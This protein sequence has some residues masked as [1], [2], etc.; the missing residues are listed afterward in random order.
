[1]K[2]VITG[3]TGNLGGAISR[4]YE[5]TGITVVPFIR[6]HNYLDLSYIRE[7]LTS[8]DIIIHAG[9]N[10]NV[11]ECEKDPKGCYIS[12][13]LFTERLAL[14]A[15][16]LGIK[17]VYISSTGVYGS[18]LNT[19]YNEFSETKP[20]TFHHQSKLLGEKAVLRCC[21]NPIIVRTGWLFGGENISKNFVLSILKQAENSKNGIIH[22]NAEQLG[23]PTYIYDV[24]RTISLL[25]KNNEIGTFNIVNPS[26]ATRFEFVTQIIKHSKLKTRV[27]PVLN[28]T[29]NRIADVSMNES[30]INLTL[31]SLGYKE[32][33]LWEKGLKLTIKNY[34]Y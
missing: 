1:M 16:S 2:I 10:T 15:E 11:E 20:T 7:A 25:I 26:P 3:I 33:E 17:F 21:S 14:I 4:H 22:S 9:A 8:C 19:P 27:I 34:G 29:F 13:T 12:N 30:A 32:L 31:T 18:Y 6:S 24:V 23:N 5:N 28:S